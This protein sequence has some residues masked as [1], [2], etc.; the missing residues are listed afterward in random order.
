MSALPGIAKAN[1]FEPEP[2]KVYAWERGL[3]PEVD[4]RQTSRRELNAALH[5]LSADTNETHWVIRNP[6]GQHAIACGLDLPIGIEIEGNVGYYCAGMKQ[7]GACDDPRHTP[8]SAS[9]RT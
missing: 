5:S 3:M 6:D 9:P 7:A 2:A 1:V 4:L 8:A